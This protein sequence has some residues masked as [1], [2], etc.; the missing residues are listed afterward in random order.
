LG[1]H[2][3]IYLRA[4]HLTDDLDRIARRLA[5]LY[6]DES[7]PFI[8][9]GWE[10]WPRCS[11]HGAFAV[12]LHRRVVAIDPASP[13]PHALLAEAYAGAGDREAAIAEL[14]TAAGLFIESGS[15]DE[16]RKANELLEMMLVWPTV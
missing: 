6:R 16:A 5:E 8:V 15:S 9:W 11:A 2:E 7:A 3:V 14:R 13:R 4:P 10:P 12:D 1:A